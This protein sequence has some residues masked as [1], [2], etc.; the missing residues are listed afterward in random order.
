MSYSHPLLQNFG[1]GPGT[2][3]H[4]ETRPVAVNNAKTQHQS[5]IILPRITCLG[6]QSQG[7]F[8]VS[9]VLTVNLLAVSAV[10]CIICMLLWIK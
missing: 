2:L 6:M 5:E 7:S 4:L 1:T 8:Q 10:L 3:P 9:P